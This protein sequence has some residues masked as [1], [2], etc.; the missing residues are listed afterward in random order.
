MVR[1]YRRRYRPYTKKSGGWTVETKSIAIGT[2]VGATQSTAVRLTTE[3]TIEGSRTIKNITVSC[4][5]PLSFRWLIV[6]VPQGT[7]VG[8][9]EQQPANQGT[10]N[11]TSIVSIYEPNQFVMA[12]GTYD[13]GAGPNRIFCPLARKLNSGDSIYL[14]VRGPDNTQLNTIAVV[15]YAI[16]YN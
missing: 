3:T 13:S 6:Y 7:T 5:V 2:S 15:R 14:V 1:Y 8:K 12:A 10:G 4:S 11:D 9:L 16:K